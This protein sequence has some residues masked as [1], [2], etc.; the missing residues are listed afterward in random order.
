MPRIDRTLALYAVVLALGGAM[1][2][3]LF[4]SIGALNLARGVGSITDLPL[5]GPWRTGFWMYPFVTFLAVFGAAGAFFAKR[6]SIA[7][8]VAGLPLAGMAAYYVALVVF[9]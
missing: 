2:V 5:D 6:E 9:G 7:V 8:G 4:W 3:L 1:F